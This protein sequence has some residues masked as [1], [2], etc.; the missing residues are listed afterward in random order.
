MLCI[1][2]HKRPVTHQRP[3]V[4][5]ACWD[6]RYRYNLGKHCPKCGRRVLNTATYCHDCAPSLRSVSKIKNCAHCGKPFDYGKHPQVRFC[7]IR[8]A[9]LAKPKPDPVDL[10]WS[11]VDRHGP[12]ECWMWQ[13]S[14]HRDGYGQ[15]QLDGKTTR[16]HRFSYI[17]AHGEIPK[18]LLVRHT[19]DHPACV[20]PA[21]LL[22][23]TDYDNCH[24]KIDRGRENPPKGSRNRHAKLT[25]S[26][27]IL[28]RQL[29]DSQSRDDLAERFSVHPVTIDSIVNGKTWRHLL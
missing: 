26:Q 29:A 13:A 27:V 15:F 5:Q 24:D 22:T 2:C 14:T 8:C 21:H 20:N 11:K 1:D 4:C 25:D 19:C 17:L 16:A 7:S 28:I 3:K 12:D 23:G 6:N 9:N 18:G 10:F